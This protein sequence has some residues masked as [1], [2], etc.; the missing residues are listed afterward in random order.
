MKAITL[1]AHF[2]GERIQLD[3]PYTL[4]PQTRLLVTVLPKPTAENE[5]ESWGDLAVLGLAA[6]YGPDEPDYSL[7]LLKERNPEYARR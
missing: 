2:D 5:R 7:D 4:K 6:A 3:E 1:T